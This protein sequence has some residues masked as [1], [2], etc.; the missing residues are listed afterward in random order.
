[1]K[2][3]PRSDYITRDKILKLLSADEL[4]AVSTAETAKH[5]MSGDEF[6]DLEKFQLG[7]QKA[8]R[9]SAPMGNV[10]PKKSVHAGT[11]AK[12]VAQLPVGL[13]SNG[14]APSASSRGSHSKVL[15]SASSEPSDERIREC[16]YG[17]YEKAD[18]RNGH[19]VDDWL[20]ATA[21]LKAQPVA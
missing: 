1:M 18:R 3:D 4:A 10:L 8:P 9:Q 16:A 11:W 19:D 6:I 17:L 5:L 7:V 20:E 13:S 12:I 15:A 2:T 14:E 21:M